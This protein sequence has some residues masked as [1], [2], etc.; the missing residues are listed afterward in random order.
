MDSISGNTPTERI[1][2]FLSVGLLQ[3]AMQIDDGKALPVTLLHNY[4]QRGWEQYSYQCFSAG[5]IPPITL[6]E[7]V[8]LLHCPLREWVGLDQFYVTVNDPLL[9]NGRPSATCEAYGADLV[10]AKILD[11]ELDD[12]Y[13]RSLFDACKQLG[14]PTLYARSREFLVR[15]PIID[16]PMTWLIVEGDWPS[17]VRVALKNCY[18]RVPRTCIRDGQVMLCPHCGWTLEWHKDMA[19]CHPGGVCGDV[20]GDFIQADQTTPYQPMLVRTRAGIQRYVVAVEIALINLY[21]KL[22]DEWG[23]TCELYPHFDAFDLL[24][25]FSSGQRWAADFKDYQR[26]RKLAIALNRRPFPFT[27]WNRAFYV[28]PDHRARPEYLNEFGNFWTPQKDV[29]FTSARS[30]LAMAKEQG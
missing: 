26:A 5:Q 14:D 15:N 4:L 9:E 11:L 8:A 29:S 17:A 27:G 10:D 16:D 1:L 30:L 23:A 2:A 25:T 20:Y 18:E 24:I 22:R 21:D 28:F 7:L 6:T 3:Q 19:N 12:K 13:F